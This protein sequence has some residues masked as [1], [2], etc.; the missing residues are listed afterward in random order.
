MRMLSFVRNSS[1]PFVVAIDKSGRTNGFLTT[2]GPTKCKVLD[3][4][5]MLERGTTTKDRRT[6]LCLYR[7]F[8]PHPG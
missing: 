6:P 2:L 4:L 1:R 3:T 5:P 8:S 7:Q